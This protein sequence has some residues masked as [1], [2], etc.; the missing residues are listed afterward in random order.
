MRQKL[1]NMLV[2]LGQ[3]MAGPIFDTAAFV[4]KEYHYRTGHRGAALAGMIFDDPLWRERI[5]HITAQTRP[6]WLYPN[7]ETLEIN[8]EAFE[9]MARVSEETAIELDLILCIV[10][11]RSI[12]NR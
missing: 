9:Q 12:G 11:L 6:V 10:D 2:K 5:N 4:A 7:R 3:K 8:R 1:Q